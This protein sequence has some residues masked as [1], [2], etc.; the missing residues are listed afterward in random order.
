MDRAIQIGESLGVMRKESSC[1]YSYLIRVRQAI[2]DKSD[3]FTDLAYVQKLI[4]QLENA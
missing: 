3:N 4:D 2:T 1:D